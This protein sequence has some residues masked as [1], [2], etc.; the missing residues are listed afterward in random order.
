MGEGTGGG[1]DTD[2]G[3]LSRHGWRSRYVSFNS[4]ISWCGGSDLKFRYT[5]VRWAR[6][7][8]CS[9]EK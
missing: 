5:P 3:G 8:G 9:D 2:V 4:C 7:Q 1:V 6:I